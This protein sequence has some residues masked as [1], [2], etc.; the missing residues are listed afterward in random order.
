SLLPDHLRGMEAV[1]PEIPEAPS[2]KRLPKV[3]P[4]R[5]ERRYRVALLTGCVMDVVYGGVNEAT[6]RVLT[7]NGCDVVIPER[8]RCCG[9]LQVHAGVREKAKA[10]A[11]QYIDALHDAGVDLVISNV[12]GCRSAMN[13]DMYLLLVEPTLPDK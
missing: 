5:G 4:A 6:V 12:A 9:A 13:N 10:L 2:R 8:Q 11:R 7:R 3:S 1:L